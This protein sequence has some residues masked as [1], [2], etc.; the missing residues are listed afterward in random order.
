MLNNWILTSS[1]PWALQAVG[2]AVVVGDLA[3]ITYVRAHTYTKTVQQM[4]EDGAVVLDENQD[5][6]E[7]A[8][9]LNKLIAETIEEK[10]GA[11]SK[12]PKTTITKTEEDITILADAAEDVESI[13]IQRAEAAKL[14]AEEILQTGTMDKSGD[15][16]FTLQTALKRSQLRL[17]AVRRYR[18]SQKHMTRSSQN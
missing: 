2:G 15:E 13:D 11:D 5:P 1:T 17:D 16:Y 14:R 12:T 3:T 18:Q 7:L 4:G 10:G 8:E 9:V 6:V